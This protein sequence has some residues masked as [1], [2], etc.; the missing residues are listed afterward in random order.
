MAKYV[1]IIDGMTQA[2]AADL[3]GWAEAIFSSE[4]VIN[5][6]GAFV[7]SQSGTPAL[8][9]LVQDGQ[10]LVLRDAYVDNDNTQKFWQVI[11]TADETVNIDSNSSGSPRIDRICLKIDTA[12]T[13]DATA[14]NVFTIVAVKGTPG[15]GAPTVPDNH[16]ALAQV[17]VVDGETTILDAD[18]TSEITYVAVGIPTLNLTVATSN[19]QVLG[20]DP[21]RTIT[22]KPGFLKPT[23]TAGSAA[24][25]QS[26]TTT[27][28][29]NYD[30]L[31][32]DTTSEEHA[33]AIFSMP[34]S[35]D[36]GVIQFR[37]KWTAASGS[38]GVAWGLAGRSFADDDALDQAVGT[39]VVVT[40]TLITAVD[41]HQTAWS[42]DVTLAGTPAA[43]EEIYLELARVVANGSDTLGVDAKL[44]SLQVRF[45]QAQFTD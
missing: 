23:T 27:N 30:T 20:V 13:P 22:L 10:A 34:D 40:D 45:K 44:I 7:V 8:S 31:D 3:T 33:Y 16:L 18:I 14:S 9:V 12:A 28:D 38:G 25:A 2:A 24:S 11:S 21:W 1:A 41:V 17:S 43:G 19:I 32:F 39:E 37:A 42:D 36:A 5:I 26:E 6:G 35:W 4:G 29:I 15:A